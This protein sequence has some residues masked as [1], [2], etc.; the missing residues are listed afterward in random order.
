MPVGAEGEDEVAIA[1]E[2]G[3]LLDVGVGP[4]LVGREDVLLAAGGG[5]DDDG[6]G[7]EV[8]VGLDLGEDLAAVDPGEVE[9]E[10]DQVGL[11]VGGDGRVAEPPEVFQGPPAVV[12]DGQPVPDARP[13]G[14]R[15][16]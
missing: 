15:A 10:Q 4:G 5:Q 3:G 2:L 12:D 13:R 8:A 1:G 16:R 14:G 6:D 9:V 11:A 7:L